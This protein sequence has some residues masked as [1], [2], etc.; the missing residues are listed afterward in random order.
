MCT[1]IA[2]RSAC[3]RIRECTS[4]LE[5]M[6]MSRSSSSNAYLSPVSFLII[7]HPDKSNAVSVFAGQSRAGHFRYRWNDE[8]VDFIKQLLGDREVLLTFNEQP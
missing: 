6:N 1:R 8:H 3:Q 4:L 5:L 7:A 2:R